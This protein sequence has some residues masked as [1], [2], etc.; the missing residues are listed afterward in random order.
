MFADIGHGFLLFLLGIYLTLFAPRIAKSDSTFKLL[1]P[2]RY[3]FALMGF[4]AFYNGLIYN[5]YLSLSLNLFGSCY[6][7][8]TV[9]VDK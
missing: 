9:I 2:A 8:K 4:F 6:E 5:D 1:L 3:M 7:Q